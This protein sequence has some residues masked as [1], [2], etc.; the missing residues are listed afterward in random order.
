MTIEHIAPERGR[1]VGLEPQ[2]VQSIGNLI[3]VS[4]VVNNE[5]G[6]KSFNEKRQILAEATELWVDPM[7]LECEAWTAESI[8]ARTE[9]MAEAAFD[10]LWAL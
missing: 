9:R 5:L 7:I 3:L 8:S 1:G 6:N 10:R 4:E 2:L